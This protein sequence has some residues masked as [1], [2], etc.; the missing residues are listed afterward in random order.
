M[1]KSRTTAER[2][3]ARTTHPTRIMKANTN[4]LTGPSGHQ[5][6]PSFPRRLGLITL[7][8]AL[9]CSMAACL[10]LEQTSAYEREMER[11]EAA[12]K[13]AERRGDLKTASELSWKKS[14]LWHRRKEETFEPNVPLILYASGVPGKSNDAAQQAAKGAAQQG[15]AQGAAGAAQA[16]Q[17]AAAAAAAQAAAAQNTAQSTSGRSGP[18][19]GFRPPPHNRPPPGAGAAAA[20]VPHPPTP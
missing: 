8:A 14:E 9:C 6:Q 10:T 13:D 1:A 20:A 12:I 17:A 2:L 18:P 3:P 19:A 5:P 11:L 15:T 16:Q 7:L 4:A